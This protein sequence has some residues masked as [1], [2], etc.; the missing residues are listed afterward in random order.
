M[1][2]QGLTIALARDALR[3]REFT[4]TELTKTYIDAVDK[5]DALGAFVHKTPEIALEQSAAA[6]L[7]LAAG[8]AP[9]LCG[10]PDRKSVV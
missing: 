6:D 7:R 10:I 8:D 1:S 5:A 3:K 9:D 2:L 4:A